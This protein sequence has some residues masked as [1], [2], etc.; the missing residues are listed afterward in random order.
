MSSTSKE[1]SLILSANID[2]K[3]I[4]TIELSLE[5]MKVLLFRDLMNHSTEKHELIFELVHRNTKQIY[6]RVVYQ[7]TQKE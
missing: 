1:K 6:D 3:Q 2:N 7:P 4:E 5:R